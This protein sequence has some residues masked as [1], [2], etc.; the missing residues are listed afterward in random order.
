MVVRAGFLIVVKNIS[1]LIYRFRFTIIAVIVA[2]SLL[3]RPQ[4]DENFKYNETR[5]LMGTTVSIDVCQ[6][7]NDIEKIPAIIPNAPKMIRIIPRNNLL[8]NPASPAT[9]LGDF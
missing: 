6:S 9:D 5:M 2:I 3:M 4:A 7:P 1:R 8:K